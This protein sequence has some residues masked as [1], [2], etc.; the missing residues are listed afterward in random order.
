MFMKDRKFDDSYVIA[1]ETDKF[2]QDHGCYV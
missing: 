1:S 2:C